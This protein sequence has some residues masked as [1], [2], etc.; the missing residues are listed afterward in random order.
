MGYKPGYEWEIVGPCK[1]RLDI[2][3][4]TTHWASQTFLQDLHFHLW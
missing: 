2:L 3:T 4:F 1:F